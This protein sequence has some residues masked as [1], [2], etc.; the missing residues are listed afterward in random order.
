MC[1]SNKCEDHLE[2]T[3]KVDSVT[4]LEFE[5]RCVC[6]KCGAKKN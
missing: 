2:K 4:S 3:L 1:S 6:N 5:I